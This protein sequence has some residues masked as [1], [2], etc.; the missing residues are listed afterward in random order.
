M[1]SNITD[2]H[3]RLTPRSDS[4]V[5]YDGTSISPLSSG[6]LSAAWSN[7]GLHELTTFYVGSFDSLHAIY[8]R[9]M[10]LSI[11][12]ANARL[13]PSSKIPAAATLYRGKVSQAMDNITGS[14][15]NSMRTGR[16]YKV[17]RAAAY[18]SEASVVVQWVWLA[19]SACLVLCGAI[20]SILV[21]CVNARHGIHVWAVWPLAAA[22]A[23]NGGAVERGA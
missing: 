7:V 14:I 21:S 15:T 11:P 5:S 16:N 19:L 4:L 23:Q 12:Y 22:A 13:L 3:L 1:Q 2:T 8:S 20:F 9:I 18:Q 17:V 6:T 10:Y